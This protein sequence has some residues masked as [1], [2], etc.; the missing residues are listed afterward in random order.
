MS[1]SEQCG[2][3][4]KQ[5]QLHL[6][7]IRAI[8]QDIN[9]LMVMAYLQQSKESPA[10]LSVVIWTLLLLWDNADSSLPLV[11]GLRISPNDSLPTRQ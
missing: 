6:V 2:T 3:E 1:G 10:R 7:L 9:L 5:R 4:S 11:I 8:L